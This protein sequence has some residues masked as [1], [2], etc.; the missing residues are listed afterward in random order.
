[1]SLIVDINPVPWEILEQVKA[2]ILRNRAK[3]QKRQPEKGKEL[4][5]VMQVDNGLL[6]KQRWEEPSFV[7]E[8]KTPYI[9]FISN[10]RYGGHSYYI[11][12]FSRPTEIYSPTINYSFF[13]NKYQ[14]GEL[15]G[16]PENY[17]P[18][19]LKLGEF[20]APTY[21]SID[22]FGTNHTEGFLFIWSNQPSN[23]KLVKDFV[24]QIPGLAGFNDENSENSDRLRSR[25]PIK[26]TVFVVNDEEPQPN[27]DIT[28]IGTHS[29]GSTAGYLYYG[30]V[31]DLDRLQGEVTRDPQ[32]VR[33]FENK[34]YNAQ[35]QIIFQLHL[36]N[37]GDSAEVE[38]I[39]PQAFQ[40]VYSKDFTYQNYPDINGS[41]NFPN[42]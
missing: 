18:T 21:T 11:P 23:H 4:R 12:G 25:L 20:Q 28:I 42:D 19:K 24:S 3:K 13:I 26:W 29:Y 5:R 30:F 8:E 27:D 32:E 2:R 39:P 22:Q 16:F 31:E 33:F 36:F 35:A 34:F 41:F 17:V 14:P 1:M 40:F 7:F 37:G 9:A 10:Y 15:S 38:G 6:A